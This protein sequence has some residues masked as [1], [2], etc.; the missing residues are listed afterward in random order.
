MFC[1]FSLDRTVPLLLCT[2]IA[3]EKKGLN[4]AVSSLK[5]IRVT[6]RLKEESKQAKLFLSGEDWGLWLNEIGFKHLKKQLLS[7]FL[8]KGS[9]QL[10]GLQ[11]SSLNHL[12]NLVYGI[13]CLSTAVIE[14]TATTWQCNEQVIAQGW[15][16]GMNLEVLSGSRDWGTTERPVSAPFSALVQNLCWHNCNPTESQTTCLLKNPM[17]SFLAVLS[18]LAAVL[19]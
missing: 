15:D 7:Y 13:C 17:L 3:P 14:Q 9:R 12:F 10:C 11:K 6:N 1:G 18:L 5:A 8:M 16:C 4:A 19:E 2:D